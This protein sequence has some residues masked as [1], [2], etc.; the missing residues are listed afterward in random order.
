VNG[1]PVVDLHEDISWYYTLGDR[2]DF[3]V[4]GLSED[5]PNRHGDIPKYKRADVAIVFAA[6]F[7]LT[8]TFSPGISK[9]LARGYDLK[10]FQR[11]VTPRAAHSTSLEHMKIYYA[12]QRVN[13][14]HIH[15][16]RTMDDI[17]E[18]LKKPLG[19]LIALEG[20]YA[21][22][23]PYDLDLF[24]N[25]GLRSLGL[26]WNFDT[27]YAATC[28]SKRDYGLTGAGEELI[29]RCND[30]G[31]I[32]DLVHAS[33]ETQL[34]VT[35]ISALPVINSHSHSK[36]MYDV[37]RNLDHKTLEAFKKNK[38]VVGAIFDKNMIGR[39]KDLRSLIEHMVYV[40]DS[41]GPDI[42]AIGTDYFGFPQGNAAT[43]LEDISMIGSLF[44]GL[45]DAGLGEEDIEK[46]A[47]KNAVRV[48]KANARR[49]A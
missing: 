22:E 27:I 26:T 8:G 17:D 23:D 6:I 33:K 24:Y 46:I 36:T 3:P 30:L 1:P 29:D 16:I 38:G 43:G 37:A 14:K 28:M 42:L 39:E 20:A 41:Y 34:E 5:V 47:Y 4:R 9:Q 18:S 32:I 45:R 13:N 7:C 12:L 44:D 31:V 35:N 40:H 49:W 19:F 48:M 21:L 25:M 15:I 2:P 10:E 11:A